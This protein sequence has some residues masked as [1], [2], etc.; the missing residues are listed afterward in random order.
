MKQ[1][2]YT[3]NDI[4]S[5]V[6]ST[7]LNLYKDLWMPDCIVGINRSGTVF[8][9]ML[10]YYIGVPMYPLTVELYNKDV[11]QNTETN[12][13][14]PEMAV[15]YVDEKEKNLIKSRWDIKK[16]KNILIVNNTNSTEFDWI[17]KDWQKTCFP[18]EE[19]MWKSVWH[20]NVRFCTLTK[21][22]DSETT[23]DYWCNEV[24]TKE[25]NTQ[26]VYPWGCNSQPRKESK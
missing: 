19:S 20:K 10:S 16:R 21:N 5:A 8:A 23:V 17:K 26:L 25:T 12:L 24:N 1:I 7:V 6:H 13:W 2:K 15:G 22:W 3:W 18:N 14:L 9:T 4:E 11:D